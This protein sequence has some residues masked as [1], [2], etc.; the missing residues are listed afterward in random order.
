MGNVVQQSI[1]DTLKN[2]SKKVLKQR[3]HIGQSL[4]ASS[5]VSLVVNAKAP[6]KTV[7]VNWSAV[8]KIRVDIYGTNKDG[9][10]SYSGGAI[11]QGQESINAT[12]ICPVF[13]GNEFVNII[14]SEK[15]VLANTINYVDLWITFE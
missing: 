10:A 7:H 12:V 2:S 14:V 4:V 13:G 5:V 15:S 6:I 3:V 11:V 1:S 9:V 8:G